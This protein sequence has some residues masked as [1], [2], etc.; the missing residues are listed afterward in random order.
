MANILTGILKIVDVASSCG[1][2]PAQVRIMSSFVGLALFPVHS[3]RLPG[4]WLPGRF[5]ECSI[6]DGPSQVCLSWLIQ[7]GIPVIP[8]SNQR[9]HLRS[10]MQ[11]RKL[12]VELFNLVDGL[13]ALR[14]GGPV[15]FLDPSRHV[16]FDIFDEE[17]DQPIEDAAAWD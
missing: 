9:E 2:S 7:K 17:N 6:T 15:R 11:V 4:G 10:N 8:K 1:M 13:A 3:P 16:G 5:P 12:S 14:L